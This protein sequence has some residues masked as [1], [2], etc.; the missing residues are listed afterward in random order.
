MKPRLS[1]V[2]TLAVSAAG[3]GAA[4]GQAA[5][6][7]LR[8]AGSGGAP[9]GDASV[10]ASLGGYDDAGADAS[11][12]GYDDAGAEGSLGTPDD[13]ASGADAANDLD[14]GGSPDS[15][16]PDAAAADGASP[17][18][19]PPS[20]LSPGDYTRTLTVDGGA[21][22]YYV[23]VP[24]GLGAASAAPLVFAF[25]GG[26]MTVMGD[27]GLGFELFA[28]VRAKSDAS[29]FVLVE[30]EGT[31]ALPG[32]QPGALDVFN[33]GNC[34]EQAEQKNANVDDV[35]LVSAIIDAVSTEVCIDP[36]RV[37]AT[38]LSNGAM[39]SHRLACQLSERIAAI[40]AVSGGMGNRDLDTFPSPTTLFP[41]NPTR[42]VPVLHIHGTQDACYPFDGGWGPL[43]LLTFE[44]VPVTVQ[45][46]VARNGCEAGSPTQVFSHGAASCVLYPC[47]KTGEVEL[48]TI[49]GGGHYWPGGD[50]WA[51]STFLCG[52]NQGVRSSD[53]IANDAMWDWFTTHPMP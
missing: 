39:L 10:D 24:Q 16:P 14:S 35:A 29:G 34:C 30:P 12:G 47:A 19:C 33:A 9:G 49:D 53:I 4:C 18:V 51:G 8:D 48:C 23:H 31:P 27:G 38:G 37:F 6:D 46:W 41:C 3:A 2:I 20:S 44:G 21:R 42:P 13:A 17:V 28:H 50:D 22:T 52:A 7:A 5:G 1:V 43:S 25:H 45:N 40:A 36:K 15:G 11:L 32:S 26:G